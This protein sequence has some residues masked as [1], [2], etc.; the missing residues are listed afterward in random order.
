MNS[1][2]EL[3]VVAALIKKGKKILLCQRREED[4]FGL[5][6]E[7]PGGKVEKQESKQEALK[8]EIKEELNLDIEMGPL[9]NVFNDE[10]AFLRIKDWLFE[11]LHFRGEII[12]DECRAFG[13]FSL[14]QIQKLNL[15][16]VDKKIYKFLKNK[17][18]IR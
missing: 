2:K 9:L 4:A 14:G 17:E 10:T 13:F 1:K 7:F 6:L 5:L 11:V 3:E 16:P 8:R 12:C 18:K 15:A